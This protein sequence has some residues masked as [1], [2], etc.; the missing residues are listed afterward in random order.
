MSVVGFYAT[1][2]SLQTINDVTKTKLTWANEIYDFG[3]YFDLANS[4]WVPP[5]GIVS[6]TASMKGTGNINNGAYCYVGVY[7]NGSE[8]ALA[9]Q[10]QLNNSTA[11][12][13]ITMIDSANGTDFY[14]AY[15]YLD[16]TTSTAD[17]SSD[18]DFTI[19]TGR[20]IE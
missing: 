4:K 12:C 10:S 5:V 7:K 1:K 8:F 19:F 9:G 20:L 17:V 16:S 11:H 14:E 13:T 2:S 18:D 15:A 6:I 3:G